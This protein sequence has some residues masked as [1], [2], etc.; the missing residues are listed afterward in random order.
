MRLYH[1]SETPDIKEFIPRSSSRKKD[2]VLVWAISEDKL[3]NY[4]LPRDCPRVAFFPKQDSAPA[5]IR[6]LIGRSNVMAVI[7]IEKKWIPIIKKTVIYKYEFNLKDFV[8]EDKCAG[9]YV[10][11]KPQ[12]PISVT[13]INNILDELF[14]YNIE[15]KVLP[16]LWKIREEVI[17]SSLDFSIIRMQN[18]TPPED[19]IENYFPLPENTI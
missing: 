4:L 7:A 10:S 1:I 12:K 2:K 14:K 15:L 19:G 17:K 11:E 18:A 13:I 3:P 6:R 9:Y 8:L 5:D 16:S